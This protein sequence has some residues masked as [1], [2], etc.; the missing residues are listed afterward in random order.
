MLNSHP[1][2]AGNGDVAHG[3]DA[4][5]GVHQVGGLGHRQGERHRRHPVAQRC[6]HPAPDQRASARRRHVEDHPAARETAGAFGDQAQRLLGLQVHQQSLGGDEHPVGRIHLVHPAV[7]QRG[8]GAAPRSGGDGGSSR[9]RMS[10]IG[11]RSTVSQRNRASGTPA[12]EPPEAGL[13]ALGQRD[14]GAPSDAH[15]D[16][17]WSGR[18]KRARATRC[19]GAV[20]PELREVEVD[21]VDEADRHRVVDD[22][23][24]T[25][26]F[27]RARVQRQQRGLGDAGQGDLR[28]L[29]HARP[30]GIASAQHLVQCA[31][32][33]GGG[34]R[35]VPLLA[36]RL[37]DGAGQGVAL[38]DLPVD[39]PVAALRS[40]RRR[41]R[42]QAP[43]VRRAP[44]SSVT[45][46]T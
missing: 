43:T 30:Y 34:G 38:G 1:R 21:R 39:H 18:R 22:P 40:S 4:G 17:V 36:H 5:H 12:L 6:P 20:R 10:T 13:Q 16:T 19:P 27:V 3:P 44:S 28:G 15:P 7:V 31:Q 25:T 29:A 9:A 37:A 23:V 14:H 11:G 33:A 32:V 8:L 26:S 2:P 46:V 24:G 35:L 42:R 41:S 45:N